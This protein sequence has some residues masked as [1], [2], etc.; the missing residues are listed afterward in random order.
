MVA[1]V[2]VDQSGPNLKPVGREA[3]VLLPMPSK[4]SVTAVPVE[5][6]GSCANKSGHAISSIPMS[7]RLQFFY[8]HKGFEGKIF[9]G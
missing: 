2:P 3:V 4:F 5:V 8:V 9:N 1:V 6:I 7:S